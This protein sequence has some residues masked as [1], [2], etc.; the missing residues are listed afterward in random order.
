[1]QLCLTTVIALFTLQLMFNKKLA[2][3]K[4]IFALMVPIT[5]LAF[6]IGYFTIKMIP[7]F[8]PNLADPSIYDYVTFKCN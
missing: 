6:V 2:Y 8:N 5:I 1:M 4:V 3:A 7:S